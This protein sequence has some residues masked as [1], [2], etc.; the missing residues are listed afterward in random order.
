MRGLI[1]SPQ[2]TLQILGSCFVDCVRRPQPQAQVGGL[3]ELQLL[4]DVIELLLVQ[5]VDV[6]PGGGGGGGAGGRGGGEGG[7]AAASWDLAQEAVRLK[8]K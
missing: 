5:S 4:L 6:R 2:I 3:P 8:D 1:K 7:C